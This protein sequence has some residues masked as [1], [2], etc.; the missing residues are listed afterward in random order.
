MP[1]HVVRAFHAGLRAELEQRRVVAVFSRLHPLLEQRD[2]LAGIGEVRP[3]GPTVSVDLTLP[4][5]DQWAGYSKKCRRIIRRAQEAGVECREDRDWRY[6][7]E[8]VRIYEETME[9]VGA[10][11]TYRFDDAY[12]EQLRA[13]LGPALRLF[14]ACL[15]GR[16]VAAGLY[17]VCHGIVQAH[18]GASTTESAW[19]SPVRLLD[20]T[21]RR[22]ASDLGAWV[23]HLGGGVGGRQDSLF[24]YKAGFSDRRHA[25]ET[26]QWVLD[27]P[28]YAALTE[29][30]VPA[31]D[32]AP[33]EAGEDNFFPAYRR[34][35]AVDSMAR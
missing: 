4:L 1:V 16:P 27:P 12:F 14:V 17:T 6:R 26:W 2:L 13:E 22:W 29:R 32:A 20:D 23:F 15:Q 9:R 21:A 34:P 35:H 24:Q 11:A 25:F 5:E 28:A 18:L 3:I 8:W 31:D 10:P 30:H 33:G 19:L 7:H